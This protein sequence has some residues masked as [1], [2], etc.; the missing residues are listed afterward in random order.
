[1]KILTFSDLHWFRTRLPEL[2]DTCKWISDMIIEHDPDLLVFCGDLNHSH[3][4]IDIPTLQAMC[5]SMW[6][7][8]DTAEAEGVKFFMV[9]GNHDQATKAARDTVMSV[10]HDGLGV[11]VC[12][13][14]TRESIVAK[15][16]DD[17]AI[18]IVLAPYPPSSEDEHKEYLAELSVAVEPEV[19]IMFSHWEIEDLPYRPTDTEVKNTPHM[20][21]SSWLDCSRLVVNG[22]YH[23]PTKH[24]GHVVLVGSPIYMNYSDNP[25]ADPRGMCLIEWDGA[26]GGGHIRR[27]ENPHGPIYMTVKACDV[28]GQSVVGVLGSVNEALHERTRLRIKIGSDDDWTDKFRGRLIQLKERCASV[29][30]T[31]K[32]SAKELVALDDA[33]VVQTVDPITVMEDHV[34]NSTTTLD[35]AL[36]VKIGR[37][38]LEAV[39]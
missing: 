2:K 3:G 27:L 29:S 17:D 26:A 35:A 13:K 38:L 20:M 19:D 33:P 10:F 16:D 32:V 11:Q 30:I 22:H 36:L 18:S 12:T 24:K 4:Y 25:V 31:G 8:A 7:I 15:R 28:G 23:H 14:P 9:P 39:E 21:E 1:V 5:D 37:E 34:K 6:Y